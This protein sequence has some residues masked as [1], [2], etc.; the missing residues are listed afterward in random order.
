MSGVVHVRGTELTEG[1]GGRGEGGWGEEAKVSSV[2][3]FKIVYM[4]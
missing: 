3:F 1:G 4:M 2:C